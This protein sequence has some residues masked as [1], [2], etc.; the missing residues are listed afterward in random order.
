[1]CRRFET[2]SDEEYGSGLL[3]A[4]RMSAALPVA[5]QR[6]IIELVRAPP[7]SGPSDL[8]KNVIPNSAL[9]A[10]A[11]EFL[12]PKRVVVSRLRAATD[13][14]ESIE[15]I[16]RQFGVSRELAAWQIIN[17]ATVFST[18]SNSE[19]SELRSWTSGARNSMF[20]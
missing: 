15:E 12:L 4:A 1:M 2:N 7:A 10:F 5:T 17:A 16:L 19:K 20:F 8:L 11:A 6:K 14:M 9:N 18:L 13:A 3:I